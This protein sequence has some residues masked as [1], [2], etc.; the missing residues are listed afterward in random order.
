ML[1]AELKHKKKENLNIVK[2]AKTCRSYWNEL[3]Q[4]KAHT[5]TH[6]FV[7]LVNF[8]R[9]LHSVSERGNKRRFTTIGKGAH[10]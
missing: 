9:S 3:Q 10:G 4:T 7:R 5:H 6:V 1:L 8:Q 2:K